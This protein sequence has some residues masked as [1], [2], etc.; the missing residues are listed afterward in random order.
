MVNT[1]KLSIPILEKDR[2][3]LGTAIEAARY[4]N[5][6]ISEFTAQAI[7]DYM[8]Y[9]NEKDAKEILELGERK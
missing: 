7:V 2:Q 6:S 9:L 4:H 1:E 3:L 8:A 5:I